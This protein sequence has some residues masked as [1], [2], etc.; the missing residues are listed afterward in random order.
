MYLVVL[1]EPGGILDVLRL[2]L[3]L[4]VRQMEQD[5]STSEPRSES[6]KA[7]LDEIHNLDWD[8]SYYVGYSEANNPHDAHLAWYP[9]KG[10]SYMLAGHPVPSRSHV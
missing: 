7:S 9:E 2:R 3:R 4:K 6:G 5:S 10:S 1:E 8:Y